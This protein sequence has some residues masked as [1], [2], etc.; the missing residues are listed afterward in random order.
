ML[1][2]DDRDDLDGLDGLE[3]LVGMGFTRHEAA[4]A[5]SKHGGSVRAAAY[6]LLNGDGSTG[7]HRN[8]PQRAR[9][10]S[11]LISESIYAWR[12]PGGCRKAIGR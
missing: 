1:P 3:Q 7:T 11:A 6:E 5:L 10:L 9:R 2:L 12:T 8:S 4:A